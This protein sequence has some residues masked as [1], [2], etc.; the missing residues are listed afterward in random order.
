MRIERREPYEIVAT[1]EG[2]LQLTPE[3]P[4]LDL[5]VTI[6]L[7][8]NTNGIFQCSVWIDPDRAL[9][10]PEDLRRGLSSDRLFLVKRCGN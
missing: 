9:P 5:D 8:K 10:I 7:G 6:D 4:A 1:K 3:R 2:I